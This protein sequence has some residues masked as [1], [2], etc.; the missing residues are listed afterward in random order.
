MLKMLANKNLIP[1]QRFKKAKPVC[2]S[3]LAYFWKNKEKPQI[4]GHTQM[5]Q[6]LTI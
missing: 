3:F 4:S 1:L 5:V 6:L 2:I